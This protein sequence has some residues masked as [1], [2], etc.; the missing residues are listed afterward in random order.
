MAYQN[1]V[2]PVNTSAGF[3]GSKL[4]NPSVQTAYVF[5][6]LQKPDISEMLTYRF[7]QYTLTTLLDRLGRNA[8]VRAGD[9]TFSWFEKGRFR[10]SY[11]VGAGS[12]GLT[13]ATATVKLLSTTVADAN[14]LVG[15]V[16]RFENDQFGFITT[17]AQN[18]ADVDLTVSSADG[19]FDLGAGDAFGHLYNAQTEFSDSPSGRVWQEEQVTEKLAIMRRSVICSTTEAGNIKWIDGG[20]SYYFRNEMETL[21]EFQFDKEMYILTGKSFGTLSTTGRQSGNGI[22]PRVLVDG[23]V[24][25]YSSAIV[26]TDIQA[27]VENMILNSPA[28]EYTVL[29]GIQAFG[30]IQKALAPYVMDGGMNY[31]SLGTIGNK[32]GLNIQQYQYM[33][34]TL[35]LQQYLPFSD[36]TIFPKPVNGGIDYGKVA[37]FVNMGS[38]SEGTPLISLKHKEDGFGNSLAFRRTVQS[39]ISTPEGNASVNRSNGKDGFTV[40]LYASI[41][42]ELRAVNN[43]G[44]L[45]PS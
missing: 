42:V 8:G 31:G 37:L 30:D 22:I 34:V 27:Q 32:V 5:A 43:H 6:D 11:A 33:G 24:G 29:C 10:K 35:N 16:L 9:D 14:L 36:T 17:I 39:G 18:S 25:N 41:G 20:R 19:D 21:K 38:D 4:G 1:T 44:I 26:E 45:L 15:D 2:N 23:V 13:S 12:S 3:T 28:R 40:D 7:P